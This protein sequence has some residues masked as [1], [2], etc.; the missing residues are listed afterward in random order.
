M[1]VLFN[2]LA[3][4]FTNKLTVKTL[5]GAVL[6]ASVLSVT[7]AAHAAEIPVE[8]S[9]ETL[10]LEVKI[11]EIKTQKS[12]QVRHIQKDLIPQFDKGGPDW[13]PIDSMVM[14]EL[15]Q[16]ILDYNY[17]RGNAHGSQLGEMQDQLVELLADSGSFDDV[18]ESVLA[19]LVQNLTA[20][21]AI[22]APERRVYL[23]KMRFQLGLSESKHL[24]SLLEELQTTRNKVSALERNL[25]ALNKELEAQKKL[26]ME[27][28]N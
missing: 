17:L 19:G 6:S 28:K 4:T 20:K 21:N 16:E 14:H 23:N 24:R 10:D 27:A 9:R 2:K 5:L 18:R 15:D 13:K 26:D 8:K 12:R 22:N 3:S 1:T 25:G 11:S 7:F